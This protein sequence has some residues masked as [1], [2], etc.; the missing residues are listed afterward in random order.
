MALKILAL[1]PARAG[2]KGL[3]HKNL[4][5]VGGVPLL[6]RAVQLANRSRRRGET[7]RV[8][9]STDSAHYRRVAE[10]AGAEVPF[11]R[12]RA[13][14]G[15]RAPLIDAVLHALATLE[16]A[17]DRFDLVVLLSAATPLT[18]VQD[19]RRAIRRHRQSHTSVVS[20]T[21]DPVPPAWRLR[22]AGGRLV[23]TAKDRIGRRQEAPAQ[24]RVCGAVYVASPAWLKRHR[25]FFVSGKSVALVLPRA[26][27]LDIED[28]V[29]LAFASVLMGR[30][31]W[32]S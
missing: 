1:I 16:Q 31:H 6:V 26:R 30:K 15:D 3:K 32:T 14:A 24:Y 11:L 22:L 23:A 7:W 29:D 2:S 21:S 20:V 8:V 10:R 19:V 5:Q 28:A 27:A 18:E 25:R 12:P 13:L 9:V 4:R 17:G